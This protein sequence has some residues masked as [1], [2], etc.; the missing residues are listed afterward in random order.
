MQIKINLPDKLTEKVGGKWENLQQKIIANLALDAFREG[1][2]DFDELKELL[3]FF[4]DTELLEFF[5]QNNMLHSQGI[6]NL[7]GTCAELDL[8]E[9]NQ[10]ICDEMD[11]DLVRA[12]NE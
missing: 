10:G 11:D 6:L 12:F 8:I 3:N 2:I 1:L 5:K 9:D 7:Y 4:S